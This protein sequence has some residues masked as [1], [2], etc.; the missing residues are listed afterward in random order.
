MRSLPTLFAISFSVI[1]SSVAVPL[2]HTQVDQLRAK[3]LSEVRLPMS[4]AT[5]QGGGIVANYLTFLCTSC[6][7]DVHH[8]VTF[9]HTS[10]TDTQHPRTPARSRTSTTIQPQTAIRKA[11]YRLARYR[12]KSTSRVLPSSIAC[13]ILSIKS[14]G[15]EA[16]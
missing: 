9:S 14:R 5:P 11:I 6:S 10:K 4:I 3:G 7:H 13:P 2:F 15:A 8:S 1:T 12:T 16:S